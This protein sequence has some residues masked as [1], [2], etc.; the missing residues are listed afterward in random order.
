MP[1]RKWDTSVW[2][3]NSEKIKT[4]I[5]WQTRD[6]FEDGFLKMVQWFQA[7]P[8]MRELYAQKIK[9]VVASN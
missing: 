9:T 3:S 5:G 2:V 6:S 4:D 7:N 8:K 1:N